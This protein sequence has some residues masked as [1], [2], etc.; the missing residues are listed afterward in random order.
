M[1]L[2]FP[3]SSLSRQLRL[4][5]VTCINQQSERRPLISFM[6]A[7]CLNSLSV[8]WTSDEL[9]FDQEATSFRSVCE[10]RP[11]CDVHPHNLPRQEG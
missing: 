11:V 6:D 9:T 5:Y 2:V 8:L 1:F 7:P 3:F 10:H 4:S